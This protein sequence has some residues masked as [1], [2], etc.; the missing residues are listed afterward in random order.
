[1]GGEG[2]QE[3]VADAV[4][5]VGEIKRGGRRLV[6]PGDFTYSGENAVAGFFQGSILVFNIM[7]ESGIGCFKDQQVF[8]ACRN[9]D[10][11]PVFAD[12]GGMFFGASV[13]EG[14]G[15]GFSVEDHSA[16]AEFRQFG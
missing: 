8:D 13:D 9:D 6:F 11:L 4:V 3:A 14:M 2:A 15:M 16:P 7:L 5:E 1:M 10:A 12:E